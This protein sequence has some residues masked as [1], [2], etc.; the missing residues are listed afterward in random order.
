M[1]IGYIINSYPMPS[2]SFIRR[3]MRALERQGVDL[4]RFSMRTDRGSL[5][6]P[7][8]IEELERTEI[9]LETAGAGGLARGV[10]GA[11]RHGPRRFFRALAMAVRLGRR[12]EVGV[13]RHA[14]YLAEACHLRRRFADLSIPHAHAH[15]GTNST[16]V[17]LLMRC[18]GGPSYSFTVHGPEEFDKPGALSLDVK[19][20]HCAFVAGVSAFG[21]S[22][23]CRHADPGDWH[24]I[25][26]VHC[27]IDPVRFATPAAMPGGVLHLVSIGRFAEQKGQLTLLEALARHRAAGGATRLTLVGD[28]PMRGWIE[29]RIGELGLAD[30]VHLT[31]WVAEAEV[32]RI[33]SG[34]HVLAMPS[35]AEGLPMVMM[36]AMAA[37]RPVLGTFIAGIPELVTPDTGWLIAAGDAAAMAAAIDRIAALPRAD[38]QH[39]HRRPVPRCWCRSR[40]PSAPT[41][42]CSSASKCLAAT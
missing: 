17:A 37:G 25:A 8:D 40:R 42:G 23:L 39:Q 14:I 20:A 2:H 32:E 24:K 6:D 21:R 30:A 41:L 27:G 22:Q 35:F 10:V 1:K 16:T 7:H 26:I 19:I 18:L 33:L 11:L 5:V 3:E 36:E 12:S 9:V 34:A 15:F 38:L 4:Q 29:R 28:G 13:L 31:G